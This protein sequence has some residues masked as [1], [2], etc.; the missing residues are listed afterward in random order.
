VLAI[1]IYPATAW[2]GAVG[3]AGAGLFSVMVPLP[4]T[5]MLFRRAT[6]S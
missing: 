5:W 2:Y 4:L 1:T 3:A 6:R